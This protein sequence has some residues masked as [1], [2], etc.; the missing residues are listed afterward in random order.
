MRILEMTDEDH[1]TATSTLSNVFI[2]ILNSKDICTSDSNVSQMSSLGQVKISSKLNWKSS[3]RTSAEAPNVISPLPDINTIIRSTSNYVI[4]NNNND[5]LL[6]TDCNYGHLLSHKSW[7]ESDLVNLEMRTLTDE[8]DDQLLQKDLLVDEHFDHHLSFHLD[9]LDHME[10]TS[11]IEQPSSNLPDLAADVEA[12]LRRVEADLENDYADMV[13]INDQY[14]QSYCSSVSSSSSHSSISSPFPSIRHD[15]TTEE[16]DEYQSVPVN[17]PVE[18][19]DKHVCKWIDCS[20]SYV[21]IEQLVRHLE[22][23]HVDQ[24]KGEDFTCFWQGCPRRY[25]PFNAR[26]KLLIHMRVHSGEKP[27]KCTFQYCG[28]AFSRLENLKI[29]LRSHTGERPYICQHAGCSKAFSN[30]SDRAKHQRTHLDTKPY[31]CQIPGC[32][33]RYTDPS[34]LRKHV[35]NHANKEQHVR[36]KNRVTKNRN[37]SIKNEFHQNKIIPEHQQS[38]NCTSYEDTEDF[39]VFMD[40]SAFD[41]SLELDNEVFHPDDDVSL[42]PPPSFLSS[43]IVP[44]HN[45][46]KILLDL[47]PADFYYNNSSSIND[48]F[49]QQYVYG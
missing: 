8:V 17:L 23:S 18:D 12:E 24:R 34:S 25:R 26:Y 49:Q 22:K 38:N 15:S 44:Q 4:N 6:T 16:S 36:K 3:K 40:N 31:A 9:H 28:K 47:T 46:A 41:L 37:N 10:W 27:N 2:Q 11:G 19:N 32:T 7:L 14:H 45:N 5:S 20:A 29:H 35:K 1:E 13:V 48:D 21:D 39:G 43:A 33:K 30:S 42:F